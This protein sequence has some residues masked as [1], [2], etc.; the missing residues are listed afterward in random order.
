MMPMGLAVPSAAATSSAMPLLAAPT[1][2]SGAG[3]GLG[4]IGG[5]SAVPGVGG[6]GMLGHVAQ[7]MM[8]HHHHHHVGAAVHHHQ[9]LHPF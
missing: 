9:R 1:A 7:G 4:G 5:L 2:I 8:H 3:L 6:H